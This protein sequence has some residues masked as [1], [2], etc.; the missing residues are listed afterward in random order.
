M[1]DQIAVVNHSLGNLN[2]CIIG[3]N[4]DSMD[5]LLPIVDII[6]SIGC[7]FAVIYVYSAY[8]PINLIYFPIS[9]CH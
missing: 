5:L 2:R 9:S 8:L 6:L 7:P 3:E 4:I 1:D